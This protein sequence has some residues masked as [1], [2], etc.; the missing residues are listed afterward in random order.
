MGTFGMLVAGATLAPVADA[1]EQVR[2]AIIDQDVIFRQLL[3]VV[4]AFE[5]GKVEDADDYGR[6]AYG[7]RQKSYDSWRAEHGLP[8]QDVWSIS[9]AEVEK[10]YFEKY[11]QPT[12]SGRL[13]MPLALVHFDGG[14]HV[15]IR[16]QTAFLARGI[17]A[18]CGYDGGGVLDDALI[19]AA[20]RCSPIQLARRLIDQRRAFYALLIERNPAK[21]KYRKGWNARLQ[22]LE[23]L[24]PG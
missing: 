5:G 14:V 7:I 11:F 20:G 17:K 22:K 24:L 16:Q 8:P 1:Q 12:A 15:G 23:S 21:E 6:T 4:L 10:I 2:Q 18:E 3:E 19:K 9:P 13:A